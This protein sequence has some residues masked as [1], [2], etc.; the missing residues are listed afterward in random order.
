[1]RRL[2]ETPA[3]SIRSRHRTL[4]LPVGPWPAARWVGGGWLFLAAAW[5]T[6][7]ALRGNGL[8]AGIA[9]LCWLVSATTLKSWLWPARARAPCRLL[10]TADGRAQLLMLDGNLH[11]VTVLPCS[12]RVGQLVLLV[13]AEERGRRHRLLLGPGNLDAPA[14]A[15]LGRCLSQPPA[16]IGIL[17]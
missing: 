14:R 5:T 2:W 4:D 1:M 7:L 13:L 17:R 15:A 6:D 3:A 16:G 10:L 12:L 8:L 9:L 11:C